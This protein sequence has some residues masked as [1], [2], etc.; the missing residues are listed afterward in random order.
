MAPRIETANEQTQNAIA[1]GNINT[2]KMNR[3][4]V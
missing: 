4:I 2:I 1:T 3:L